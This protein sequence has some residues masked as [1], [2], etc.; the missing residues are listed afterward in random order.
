MRIRLILSLVIAAFAVVFTL[1][2]A[3]LVPVK[4]LIW[5]FESPLALVL[6]VT[7]ILGAVAAV[8]VATPSSLR[9]NWK[10]ARETRHRADL[11]ARV[12]ELGQAVA[13]KDRRIR[14]FEA[15]TTDKAP[16]A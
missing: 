4:F 14:E 15:R 6:A 7:L 2:N 12:T 3:A 9:K 10:I 13:E 1:Q 16:D 5:R 8:L 11:E